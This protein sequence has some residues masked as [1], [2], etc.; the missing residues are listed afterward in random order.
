M[1]ESRYRLGFLGAWGLF[2]VG[3][4]LAAAVGAAEWQ[5]LRDAHRLR[6]L[7]VIDRMIHMEIDP[8]SFVSALNGIAAQRLV[9][10]VCPACAE[11]DRPTDELLAASGIT[12][13]AA[14][15]IRFQIGRGCGQCR[16]SGYRGRRAIAEFLVMNDELR[17]LIVSR[18]SI[19]TLK[20]TA[21]KFGT[22]LLREAAL[23]LVK[24][25]ETT[26]QEINRVTFV[27]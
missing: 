13:E 14:R 22:R 27:S 6:K 12:P 19:R 17:E 16:G 23:E 10:L 8:H 5:N 3:M 7:D 1:S 26:L 24:S 18:Q 20:L 25:G 2:V 9:R 15:A 11:E 4:I 21:A